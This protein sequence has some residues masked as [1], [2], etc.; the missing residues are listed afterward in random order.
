MAKKQPSH[1]RGSRVNEFYNRL[2]ARLELLTEQLNDP[3]FEGSRDLLAGEVK[4]LRLV[5]RE[6][7]TEFNCYTE[8]EGGEAE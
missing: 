3:V 8:T 7:E 5:V 4:A 2:R 6:L 1:F